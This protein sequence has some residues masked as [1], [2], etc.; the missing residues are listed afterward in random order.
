M[1]TWSR[2][3]HPSLSYGSIVNFQVL[4]KCTGLESGVDGSGLKVTDSVH[5]SGIELTPKHIPSVD[6]KCLNDCIKYS[7]YLLLQI[8][9]SP[10]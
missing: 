9:K 6:A 7:C 2:F 10:R 5:L 1:T 8:P 3:V 4:F